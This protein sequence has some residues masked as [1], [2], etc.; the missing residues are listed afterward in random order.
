MIAVLSDVHSNLEALQAVRRDL[1]RRGVQRAFFLGDLVGYGPDPVE[2]LRFI[3]RFEFCLL[4]NHDHA[5]LNGPPRT[6]N[7]AARRATFWTRRQLCPEEIT[8]GF[9]RP[10]ELQQRRQFWSFLQS[11]RPLRQVGDTLFCHD[12]PAKP[13][14]WRYVRT[15]EDADRIFQAHPER[16]AFFVGHSHVPGVWT[17]RE[18]IAPEPGQKFD[19]RRRLVV[20]VGAVGQPRDGDPRACYVILEADG[21]RFLRVPYELAKTQEK[22][23]RNP[24]LDPFLAERLFKGI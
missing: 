12:T 18:Y 8:A 13:G 4:G 3:R 22:I 11:L 15:Q 2:V 16:R 24:E 14:S 17:E 21:F 1:A 20:N 5:V 9:L 23:L 10:R 7:A 6:F 19:F